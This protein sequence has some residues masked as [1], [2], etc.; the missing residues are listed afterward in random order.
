MDVTPADPT[1][2]TGK[3]Q[4]FYI[5]ETMLT[6]H[7]YVPSMITENEPGHAPM[8]G[9]PGGTPWYW[10]HD[11]AAAKKIAAESN[12]RLGISAA[13]ALAIVLSSMTADRQPYDEN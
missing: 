9:G 11:L 7:G 10:G 12:A 13:D 4:C 6:E 2:P 5:D 8:T 1:P 3:R